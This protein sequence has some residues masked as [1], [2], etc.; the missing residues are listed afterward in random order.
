M[1][2]NLCLSKQAQKKRKKNKTQIKSGSEKRINSEIIAK[3][4][5]TRRIWKFYINAL[6]NNLMV[7][8]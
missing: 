8:I 6:F 2:C 1:D 4:S 7:F 5:L 3:I